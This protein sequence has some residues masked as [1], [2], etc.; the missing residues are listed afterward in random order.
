MRIRKNLNSDQEKIQRFLDILGNG[1]VSLSS[2]KRVRPEFF[3]IAYEFIND[4]ITSVFFKKEEHLIRVL[5]ESG[6]P[7]DEG[8]VCALRESQK[9]GREAA[10]VLIKAAKN[11]QSGDEIARA[12]VIWACS[13]Y[14]S[15]L[16]QHL[17]KL[18][19]L[20]FPL[21]EQ[22]IPVD[23]EHKISEGMSKVAADAGSDY[24]K[25]DKQISKLEEELSDWM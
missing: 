23:D 10:N 11:W 13:E 17:D 19:N 15:S 16:R 9:R 2:K 8:P 3:I 6:F 14:T 12:D 24:V 1:F 18:K 5:E 4:N 21:L 7:T 20:V 25:W 22:T